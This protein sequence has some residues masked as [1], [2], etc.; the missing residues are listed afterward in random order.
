M[1]LLSTPCS[2]LLSV[3]RFP[4]R[5]VRIYLGCVV[6][7]LVNPWSLQLC[8]K[9][10]ESA[11]K[12]VKKGQS[13]KAP[14]DA[15]SVA[16]EVIAV[17]NGQ[18]ISQRQLASECLRRY[19]K[20]VLESQVNKYLILQECKRRGITVSP[21][22]IDEEVHRIAGQFN[23]PVERW[24]A[25]LQK[26]R[27]VAPRQYR[28]DIVWPTLAL[29]KLSRD[30]LEITQEDVE[31]AFQ[32]DYGPKIQ[33]RLISTRS[34]SK[35][36]KLRADAVANPDRFERLAKDHSEDEASASVRGL[37]P[38][39]RR[40][41]GDPEIEAVAFRMKVN[42]ISPIVPV[43]GQFMI[44]KCERRIPAVRMDPDQKDQLMTELREALVDHKLRDAAS[45]LFR[46]LQASAE[47]SNV[48]NNQELSQ[49]MP[50]VAAVV[51][52]QKIGLARV[53]KECV[54]RHGIVILD[55]EINRRVLGQSLQRSSLEVTKEDID[56]E[57]K[58]AARSF[59][60]VS[61]DGKVN[62]DGWLEQIVTEEK[63]T[64]DSY[65][66]DV[67][68]PTVALKKLVRGR[69][70][71]TDE[72]LQKGFE[73]NYGPRVE[74]MAMV[75][76]NQRTAYEVF[77]MARNNPTEKFFGELANQYS[78]EPVSKA[79]FGIVPP[80]RKNGGRPLLEK[81]AF[82]LQSGEISGIIAQGDKYII[83]RCLGRTEPIVENL[84]VVNDELH[85]DIFEKKLRM[86]MSREFDRLLQKAQIDNFLAKT[87][88]PGQSEAS[89][90]PASYEA[91][92]P[93]RPAKSKP[94]RVR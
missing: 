14:A 70:D 25:M 59:G 1:I 31:K 49:K 3:I 28:R 66:R 68:W 93:P 8:A 80:I 71:V 92:G 51:N 82:A 40:H 50:G 20:E 16:A 73:A 15:E 81:E 29:R 36:E 84:A 91:A 85:A 74:V 11:N 42:Q 57:I 18:T 94:G 45:E 89:V 64:V 88:Q 63:V 12:S 55:A 79:N 87:T 37:I 21:G 38:P 67:V 44:L 48:L 78:I 69:I 5:Y 17:V 30:K 22:E 19:G 10:G 2:H 9:G 77:E 26:E 13:L 34:R 32:A 60:F 58:R 90:A 72:D 52:G 33:V 41:V 47:V 4:R 54:K 56:N 43:E 27:D 35:A 61:R 76:S 53:E 65:V 7:A 39:I 46:E 86:A 62:V 75:L 24:Y 83:L 23:L 6:L